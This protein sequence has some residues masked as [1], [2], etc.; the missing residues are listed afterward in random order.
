MNLLDLWA[1]PH[2][3]ARES[4][5]PCDR[6]CLCR[7]IELTTDPEA[8]RGAS[9]PVEAPGASIQGWDGQGLVVSSCVVT[10]YVKS[11]VIV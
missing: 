6:I 9:P 11:E 10:E 4:E 3:F 8:E 1:A 2:V 5:S 7:R